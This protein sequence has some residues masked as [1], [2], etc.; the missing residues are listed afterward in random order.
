MKEVISYAVWFDTKKDQETKTT[1]TSN[2]VQQVS[3]VHD[4]YK[5]PWSL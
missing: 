1:R 2:R 4:Q 5:L 3:W